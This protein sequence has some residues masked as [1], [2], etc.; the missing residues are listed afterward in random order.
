MFLDEYPDIPYA[1]LSYT[2]GECN[3]GGKVTDGHDRHTLMTILSTYYNESVQQDG[4]KF[5]PSGLYYSPRDLDYKGYLE[6]INGLP[7][8]AEPEVF[9]MHD[10][11]NITKVWRARRA[12]LVGMGRGGEGERE[13]VSFV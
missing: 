10:N 5:S 1:A 2:C 7:A 12:A 9:G 3:Y 6:Y 4:Y 11:A 8:I 13:I